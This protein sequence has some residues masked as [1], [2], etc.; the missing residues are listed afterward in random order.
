M[1]ATLNQARYAMP[2]SKNEKPKLDDLAAT[3]IGRK[4]RAQFDEMVKEPVPDRF[5]NLLNELQAA[6]RKAE[7]DA[8]HE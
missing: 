5:L 4:L 2:E 8:D 6:E 1:T 7:K 3:Q